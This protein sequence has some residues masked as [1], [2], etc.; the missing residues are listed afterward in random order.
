MQTID[1]VDHRLKGRSRHDSCSNQGVRQIINRSV[2][3]TGDTASNDANGSAVADAVG[4]ARP[5]EAGSPGDPSPPLMSQP[6]VG[7]GTGR[8]GGQ[9][10]YGLI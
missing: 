3:A 10:C 5:L 4:T 1:Q 2:G 7:S 9:R 8:L 6:R